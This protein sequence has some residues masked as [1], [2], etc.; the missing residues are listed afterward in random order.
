[1]SPAFS[2]GIRIAPSAEAVKIR[3]V[4]AHAHEFEIQ[5]ELVFVI[6]QMLQIA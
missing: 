3:R 1:M 2:Y 6:D 4:D 5:K